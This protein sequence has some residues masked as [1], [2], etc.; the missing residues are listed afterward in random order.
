M[1]NAL[2]YQLAA[3]ASFNPV[4][5]ADPRNE[6]ARFDAANALFQVGVTY[7]TLGQWRAAEQQLSQAL[8]LL[9]GS[10]TPIDQTPEN[11]R[12]LADRIRAGIATARAGT[13]ARTVAGAARGL[14]S[15]CEAASGKTS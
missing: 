15:R 2:K 14:D 5:A 6:E 10:S 13:R 4:L 7:N 3:V 8:A 9:A 11:T 12:Q 1:R